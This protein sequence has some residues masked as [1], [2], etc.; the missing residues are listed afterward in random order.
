MRLHN[1]RMRKKRGIEFILI[2]HFQIYF[3]MFT[4][5]ILTVD[6]FE[7]NETGAKSSSAYYF[8]PH[9]KNNF[10]LLD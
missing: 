2:F 4:L 7:G 5:T 1:F 9:I 6:V 10:I 8:Y 3:Y